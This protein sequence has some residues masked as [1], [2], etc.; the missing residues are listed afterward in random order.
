MIEGNKVRI[1]AVEQTD[2]DEIMKWVNDPEVIDNLLM[3]YPM[4]RY[5]EKSGWRKLL[6]PAT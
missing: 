1:R 2:L 5:L 4:S 6:T 3:R